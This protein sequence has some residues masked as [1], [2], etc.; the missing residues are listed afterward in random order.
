MTNNIQYS[1]KTKD[2]EGNFKVIRLERDTVRNLEDIAKN[3]QINAIIGSHGL[4]RR[5]MAFDVDTLDY[6]LLC[7]RIDDPLERLKII[8][9]IFK[10][11]VLLSP[12]SPAAKAI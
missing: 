5:E 1:L 7:F 11:A 10:P 4:I 9:A 8:H 6:I 2:K 3:E 12:I